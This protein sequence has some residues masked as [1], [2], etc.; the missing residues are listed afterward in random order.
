MQTTYAGLPS[1]LPP[2]LQQRHTDL[3]AQATQS[4]REKG[5]NPELGDD[6]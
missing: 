4:A 3:Y 5:W 1:R 2:D 6:E